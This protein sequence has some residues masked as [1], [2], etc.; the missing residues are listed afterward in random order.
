MAELGGEPPEDREHPMY[1]PRLNLRML[2]F[3]VQA[4]NAT[5]EQW[6][7]Q[8]SQRTADVLLKAFRDGGPQS[9]RFPGLLWPFTTYVLSGQLALERETQL[10]LAHCRAYGGDWELAAAL[11]FRLHVTV[12]TRG[13]IPGATECREE[14]ESLM[15]RVSDRWMR[16]QVHSARAEIDVA[17]GDYASAR[18]AFEEAHRLGRELGAF[19]EGA[20]LLA[21]M[22]DLAHR[23]GEPEAARELVVQAEEEAERFS[24][25]DART[26][27]RFLKSTLLLHQGAV[28]EARELH[29][30]AAGHIADGTPPPMF[31]VM[32]LGLSALITAAEGDPRTALTILEDATTVGVD[33]GC[34]EPVLGGLLDSAAEILGSLGDFPAALTLGAASTA[35]RGPLP[36]SIPERA[37]AEAVVAA[38][39]GALPAAAVARARA[40]G[41]ALDPAAAARSLR[42]AVRPH[43]ERGSEVGSSAEKAVPAEG[44][45]PSE[46]GAPTEGTAFA[47]E[48]RAAEVGSASE[49][50]PSAG[51]E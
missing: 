1:W 14:L 45:A 37:S 20:F 39:A 25:H 36:R 7:S 34:T 38:A 3:F 18:A 27:I 12:D 30:L 6:S 24:V 23:A 50:G 42:A 9:A 19:S 16:A 8:Q 49:V 2:L 44:A 22:A 47:V 32:L 41:A 13:G 28:S 43:T 29:D 10:A 4:D 46:A 5:E 40:E 17:L 31:R 35:I 48:V 26:Y 11:M 15:E 21:R 33:I 51:R